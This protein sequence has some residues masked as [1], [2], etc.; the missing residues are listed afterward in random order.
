M[1][2]FGDLRRHVAWMFYVTFSLQ[3]FADI[4]IMVSLCTILLRQHST[5]RKTRSVIGLLVFYS[6]NTCLLTSSIGVAAVVTNAVL[7]NKFYWQ[8]LTVMLPKLMLNSLLAMLNTRD[9]MRKKMMPTT[10]AL[11]IHLTQLGRDRYSLEYRT[12]VSERLD[13]NLH[14]QSTTTAEVE[15]SKDSCVEGS[16]DDEDAYRV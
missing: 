7:P 4:A 8:G 1:P 14:A 16:P 3:A 2:D 5:V 13:T 11:S 10:G 6:V 9:S 12:N 15:I